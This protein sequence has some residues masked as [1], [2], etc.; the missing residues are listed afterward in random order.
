MNED[1][2]DVG[3]LHLDK[4]PAADHALAA[5]L[6][7]VSAI[8]FAG[9]PLAALI[10][11]YVPRQKQRRLVSFIEDLGERFEAEQA[12]IDKE[13]VTTNEFQ[14]MVEDVLDRVQQRRNEE[15]FRY[16]AALLAG[17]AA[18]DRPQR[19]DRERMVDTL[20]RLRVT[21]LHLL[22]VV[23]TTTQAKPGFYMG[24]VSGT[25]EWKMPG[26]PTDDIRRDWDDLA[27]ETLLQSYPSGMMSAEGAGNLTVRLTPYGREFVRLLG[28]ESATAAM[29]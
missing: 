24:G 15:K 4:T 25:L 23:A 20:D 28:I 12:R 1:S 7:A 9:G 21:H 6:A 14:T 16:W 26:V 19:A 29:G 8:P 18:T 11:E 3:P 5:A 10:A 17:V 27:R 13:F 22:H 2:P